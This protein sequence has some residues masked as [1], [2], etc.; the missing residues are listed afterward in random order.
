MRFDEFASCGLPSSG[1]G[2]EFLLAAT[3]RKW[4]TAAPHRT[5]AFLPTAKGR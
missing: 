5:Q 1:I 2:Q 3:V 4:V